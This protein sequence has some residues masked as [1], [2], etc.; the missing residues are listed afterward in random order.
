[1]V[2]VIPA[3]N[4]DERLIQFLQ[5]LKSQKVNQIIVVN[6]G[7]D[8]TYESIFQCVKQ[9]ATVIEYE[10]NQ[11]KG[12]ALK[13][14]FSYILA[15]QYKK[16]EVIVTA[17]ADGQHTVKDV[18]KTVNALTNRN[19]EVM[20]GSRRF[21]GD[22]PRKSKMGNEITRKVFQKA[23]GISVWDTQTGLRAFRFQLLPELIHIRGE[24]YEYEMNMLLEFTKKK[25]RIGEVPIETIYLEQNQSSHFRAVKD[26]ICIYG[27]IIRFAMSSFLGFCIDFILYWILSILLSGL[28]QGRGV[29]ISNV[30][31]RLVSGTINFQMNRKWVFDQNHSMKRQALQ[32]ILLA[33][34]ILLANSALLLLFVEVLQIQ[35]VIAKLFVEI[36]LFLCSF[37]VQNKFIFRR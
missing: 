29:F 24:R 25:I 20:L 28:G 22:I 35:K 31:A 33:M 13:T 26:S 17:D 9:Y 14:A 32:Y 23:T 5:R 11:G 10:K 6:D 8:C 34:V 19:A 7:S 1:M 37:F 21:L 30:S 15:N 27:E 18:I 3:Y 16:T 36:I 12:H 2:V 4:P